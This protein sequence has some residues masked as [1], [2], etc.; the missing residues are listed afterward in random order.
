MSKDI[1]LKPRVSEKAYALSEAVNTYAFDVPAEL[2]KH[3]IAEAVAKQYEVSVTNVRITN[4]PG[5][6]KKAYRKRTR[7]IDVKRSD[8]R[9]AYVTLKEGDNLPFFAGVEEAEKEEQAVQ[10]KVTKAME[11]QSAK[12]AKAEA[13]PARRGLHL[14]QNRGGEK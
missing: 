11:K 8:I 6:A 12:E 10:A 4:I 3:R 5:K 14:R 2:N 7:G 1:T 13:R 9:K